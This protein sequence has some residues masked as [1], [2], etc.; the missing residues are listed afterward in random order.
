MSEQSAMRP[1]ALSV[2]LFFLLIT[3]CNLWAASP[4]NGT[5]P[6]VTTFRV[7]SGEVHVAISAVTNRN[8]PVPD[9][10]ANDFVLLRDG[11]PV[12]QITSFAREQTP[13]SALVLTDV[14][15]SMQP[16]LTLERS[17]A[18]WLQ[19]NSNPNRDHLQFLDFG[20]EVEPTARQTGSHLTSMYDSL[21]KTLPQVATQGS[22]RRALIL[23]SDGDD[24][25]SFH[26]LPDV[27]EAAQKFDV[28]IYAVT[29]HPS[30]KQYIAEDVLNTLATETGGRFYQVRNAREMQSALSA[31]RE[32]LTNGY[33][34]V[35]RPDSTS[36]GVHQLA[37]QPLNTKLKFFYRTAYFQPENPGPQIA[38]R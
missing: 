35:F 34:L 24:N 21:V 37:I 14:S 13:V 8:Q 22:G 31:I 6:G 15:E 4:E 7:T 12:E 1:S 17:A 5:D 25:S 11:Q 36:P 19:E 26:A 33:D 29:A 3:T 27:I 38:Q 20:L 16:G 30:R 23:L 9:L 10:S 32:Q 2:F 28:A 18:Q